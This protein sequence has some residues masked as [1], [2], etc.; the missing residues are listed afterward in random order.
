[1]SINDCQI[2]YATFLGL[3]VLV[4]TIST[5]LPFIMYYVVIVVLVVYLD[6]VIPIEC[7]V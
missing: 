1:M 7:L 3:V 4:D 6:F 2:N 5:L